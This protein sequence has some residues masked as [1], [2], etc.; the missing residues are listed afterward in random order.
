MAVPTGAYQT[1]QGIGNREDLE[2]AFYMISPTSTPFLT[3]CGRKKA[4]LTYHEW[5]TDTLNPAGN[6]IQIEGDDASAVGNNNITSLPGVRYGNYIQNSAKTAVVTDDQEASDSAGGINK[7]ANQVAKRMAELKLDMELALTQNNKSSAGSATVARQ[8]GS[9]E[10][11]LWGDQ[12]AALSGFSA[13]MKTGTVG[14]SISLGDTAATTPGFATLVVAGPTDASSTSA[15]VVAAL[16]R[17]IKNCW[18]S[19]GD[20]QIIMVGGGTKQVVSGFA[21]IATIFREAGKTAKGTAIIGAADLYI[22]DFGEHRVIPNRNQ[23]N[24]TAFVLDMDFWDVAYLR[25]I[26]QKE[27]A[28]TGSAVKRFIDVA[29]TLVAKNPSSSGKIADLTP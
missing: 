27:I 2:D 13:V 5:L 3:M 24:R 7:M 10:S 18:Q 15:F 17:V 26:S 20:P 19:G 11:W 12:A 4:K 28:R 1:Y 29:Y 6:N 22:S 8:L 25:P 23:R 21:G 14:N 16:K 9:L